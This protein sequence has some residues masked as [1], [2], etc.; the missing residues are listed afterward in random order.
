MNMNVEQGVSN[1][2]TLHNNDLKKD[3]ANNKIKMVL[4]KRWK[5]FLI[6]EIEEVVNIYIITRCFNSFT[7]AAT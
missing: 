1:G 4:E 3:A 2:W 7:V 6:S 5:V